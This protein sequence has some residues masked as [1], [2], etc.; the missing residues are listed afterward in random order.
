[1]AKTPRGIKNRA[2]KPNAELTPITIYVCTAVLGITAYLFGE[3]VLRSYSHPFH[4]G[5][6][7]G[8]IVL[9]LLVG[10]WVYVRFGDIFG[11]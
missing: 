10:R 2:Q 7:L 9:G 6:A 3:L 1:M 4:W 8:G 5:A 11:F